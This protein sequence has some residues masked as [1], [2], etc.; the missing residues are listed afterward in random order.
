MN[1]RETLVDFTRLHG[2]D[3]FAKGHSD[4]ATVTERLFGEKAPVILRTADRLSVSSLV[5]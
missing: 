5:G 4:C 2:A 1:R 3:S